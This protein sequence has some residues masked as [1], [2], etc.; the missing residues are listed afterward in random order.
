MTG[1]TGLARDPVVRR[2]DEAHELGTFAVEEGVRALPIDRPRPPF[3][4]I[5]RRDV[6]ALFR[7][8]VFLRALPPHVGGGRLLDSRAAAVAV[9]AAQYDRLLGMHVG[10]RK[11]GVQGRSEE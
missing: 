11:S 7:R 5:T 3:P 4:G 1:A 8:V 10:G 6:G 2:I 9:G